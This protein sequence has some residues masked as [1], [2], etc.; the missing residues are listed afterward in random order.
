M[1]LALVSRRFVSPLLGLAEGYMELET[2][3]KLHKNL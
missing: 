3:F 1:K 2:H